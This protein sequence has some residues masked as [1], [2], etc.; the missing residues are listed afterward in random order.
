M[1][2]DYPGKGYFPALKEV[3]GMT[4]ANQVSST[5]VHLL[6]H[7]VGDPG[8]AAGTEEEAY[9]VRIFCLLSLTRYATIR[10]FRSASTM[11]SSPTSASPFRPSLSG[12]YPPGSSRWRASWG[13][14]AGWTQ[15]RYASLAAPG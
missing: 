4:A 3:T 12:T 15:T 7:G 10:T 2:G 1:S 14:Q 11:D 6:F 9:F 8:P 13:G 5:I